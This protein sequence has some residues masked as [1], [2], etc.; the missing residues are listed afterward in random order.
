MTE[1]VDRVAGTGRVRMDTESWR[2][3]TPLD[4]SIEPGVEVRVVEVTG[5]RLVVEPLE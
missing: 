4:E 2:A 5:A 1:T 3:T